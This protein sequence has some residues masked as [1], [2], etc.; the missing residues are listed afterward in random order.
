M[1][2]PEIIAHL[3]SAKSKLLTFVDH[4]DKLHT[5]PPLDLYNTTTPIPDLDFESPGICHAGTVLLLYN[6][7]TD[8]DDDDI[9]VSEVTIRISN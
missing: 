2:P 6:Q 5:R 8:R 4:G 9:S 7:N 3:H 1:F